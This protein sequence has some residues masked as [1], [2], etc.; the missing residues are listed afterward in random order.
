M[1]KVLLLISAFFA[2]LYIEA[3]KETLLDSVSKVESTDSVS[4][5]LPE[6]V[7]EGR[8]QR[9]VKFGVEYIPDKKQRNLPWMR[10]I[11]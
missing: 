8:T 4:E 5:A 2:F 1:R 9:V 10:L 3:R 11:F 7:V 6:V